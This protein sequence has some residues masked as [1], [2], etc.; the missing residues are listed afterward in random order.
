MAFHSIKPVQ[1]TENIFSL[2]SK[3]WFLMSAEKEGRV[4]PMTVAWATAGILWQKP[5]GMCAVR[6]ERFPREFLDASGEVPYFE[7]CRMAILCKKLCVTPLKEED[8][9]GDKE[10]TQKWYGG[11]NH[12]DGTGGGYHLLYIAEISDIL[13]K[14]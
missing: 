10:F 1:I 9:L 8:F 7:E 13:V 14:D 4:N 2:I 11:D 12:A 3:D 6:P 5:V